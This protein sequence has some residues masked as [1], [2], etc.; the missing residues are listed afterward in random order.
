MADQDYALLVGISRYKDGKQF[1]ALDGPLNDVE[2]VRS[3]LVDKN[4]GQAVPA[5]NVKELTTPVDLLTPPLNGWSPQTVWTPNREGFST[6]FKG[7]AFDETGK[8]VR[9]EG[10]LYLYFSG[11]GFSLND[12]GFPSAA[13]FSADNVGLIHSNLAGT[14]YAT[15][16]KRAKLFKEVV[17]IMDCCRDVF[18]NLAYNEPDFNRVENSTSD[19]VKLYALYAAPRR[20]KSQERELPD[21]GGK[22]VGLMTDAILRALKEGPSDVAGQVAG[23]V[24]TQ[25]MAFNWADWY[26]VSPMPPA[27]RGVSPD[28]GDIY[29]KSLQEGLV[30]V[31]VTRSK[32]LVP[33]SKFE[34]RSD[35]WTA[36]ATVES[37]SLRWRDKGYSWSQEIPLTQSPDTS[38]Q[39]TLVLPPGPHTLA[40]G[41][42]TYSFDPRASNDVA[43]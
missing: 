11:H 40:I 43:I 3:W 15:A 30:S 37:S 5:D 18:G 21:S 8:M 35:A 14:V 17:L 12:D 28:E 32:S 10:R 36:V 22:V 9:R 27:P 31:T 6:L 16:V 2:R 13:L 42:D 33:G 29:F 4:Y 24:L 1:P 38:Q 20:G 34:L 7:I 23:R 41:A 19:K 39:F 26:R 25:V